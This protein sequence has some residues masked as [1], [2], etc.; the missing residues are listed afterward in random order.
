[1]SDK[2]VLLHPL[3]FSIIFVI[4]P[5]A[6]WDG[7]IPPVQIVMPF[8]AICLLS[9][10][11]YL[12][13]KRIVKKADVAVALLSPL[14]IFLL[15]YGILHQYVSGIT[16]ETRFKAPVLIVPVLLILIV[17]VVF[18]VKVLRAHEVTIRIVNKA[19]FAIAF[20]LLILNV[21]SVTKQSLTTAKVPGSPR[22]TGSNLQKDTRL[23]PDIYFVVLDEYAAPSQ[24][25][26]YFQYDMSPF[27]EYL[28]QK[29]FMVTEMYTEPL[30]TT[31]IMEERLNMEAKGRQDAALPSRGFFD[32]IL[33]SINVSNVHEEENLIRIRKNKVI[34][35]LKSIGYRIIHME[36]MVPQMRYNQF[37]DQNIDTSG[38]QV[39]RNELSTIIVLNSALRTL[40][41]RYTLGHSFAERV[42]GAFATLENMPVIA[43]KP[44]F[45]FAHVL[46][47]H[48]P[49]LFGANGEELGVKRS[50]SKSDKEL[51]FDQ[52]AFITKKIKELVDYKLSRAQT[53][54]VLI[55][56]SD[57]GAKMDSHGAHQVFS[58][59]YIPSHKGKPWQDSISSSNTFRLLFNELFGTNLEIL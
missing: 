42:L 4:M 58:A 32:G 36:S 3:L 11:S 43:G 2:L 27:V 15:N 55:I 45:I 52:H 38:G 53:A 41:N 40:M 54:P 14:L 59:V 44:K 48:V 22:L 34:S 21:F 1:M 16:G 7:V 37:A 23:L 12:I 31:A 47:P 29:G 8:V 57:H 5:Y 26:N 24:M 17:L 19:F 28:G 20:V 25:K 13:I 49:Y 10:S 46:C 9:L 39:T 33:E 56:Q 18:I 51:Y 35:Y 30:G 50:K 6:Q